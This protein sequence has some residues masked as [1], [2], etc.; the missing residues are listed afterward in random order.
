MDLIGWLW[1]LG[2]RQSVIDGLP[3]RYQMILT[4]HINN[5]V[6]VPSLASEITLLLSNRIS[7]GYRDGTSIIKLHM[8][9]ISVLLL[10]SLVW[11]WW[12]NCHAGED[13]AARCW[14]C[15]PANK[16][17]G[18]QSTSPQGTESLELNFP[19][20]S[21][22][23]IVQI[24]SWYLNCSLSK[25][26]EVKEDSGKLHPGFC[27]HRN[28]DIENIHCFKPLAGDIRDMA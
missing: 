27:P 24:P 15:P 16:P 21:K 18:P 8:I 13:W 2:G 20:L 17:S 3:K 25:S 11:H 23:A 6:S 4:S 10:D 19:W 28:C 22:K 7:Q 26:H 12:G 14:G 5:H 1:V 9:V